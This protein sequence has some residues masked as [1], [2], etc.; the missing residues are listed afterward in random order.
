MSNNKDYLRAWNFLTW[1][2]G[3]GR[4][5]WVTASVG[6]SSS[7]GV[8]GSQY[9]GYQPEPGGDSTAERRKEELLPELKKV[10]KRREDGQR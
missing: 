10:V 7:F 6:R 3:A 5:E 2:W 8:I 9:E 4:G 1:G